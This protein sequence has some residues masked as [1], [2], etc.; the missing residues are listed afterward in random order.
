MKV[1]FLVFNSGEVFITQSEVLIKDRVEDPGNNIA[2]HLAFEPEED[3]DAM[4]A[5]LAI[6][7]L[8]ERVFGHSTL[9]KL[10]AKV[11]RAGVEHG[12]S[13]KVAL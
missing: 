6:H 4:D 3:E 7:R 1:F 5:T 9:E 10:A 11:F 2:A 8:E 12:R 13:G